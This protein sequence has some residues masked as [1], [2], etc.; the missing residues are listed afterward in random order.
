MIRKVLYICEDT[1]SAQFRYRCHNVME[2]TRRSKKWQVG[3]LTSAELEKAR[4]QLGGISLIVVERQTAKN[5]Q[6][7]DFVK[8][9][10]E[11]G[12]RVLYD[13]D[14]LVFDLRDLGVLMSATNSR[15]VLYWAGYVMGV[16]RLARVCDGFITTNEYLGKRLEKSF[17]KPFRVIHNSLNEEQIAAS[18][19]EI[20]KK[21]NEKEFVVGYFSGSPTHV[22]DFR[23]VEPE[24]IKFLEDFADAKLLIVGYMEL[25]E[26]MKIL[27]G[28]GRVVA[29]PFVEYKKLQKLVA[30][31]DVNIAPLEVNVFTN[32]KSE[33]KFFEAAVVETTTIASPAYAFKKAIQDGKNGFLVEPGGWY[34]KLKYLHENPKEN[35]AV[36]KQARKDVMRKYAGAELTKEIEAAYDFFA[37]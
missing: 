25:S 31:V 16:R 2:W 29:K 34:E 4:G 17:R 11:R 3:W 14:D 35:V 36:A 27:V 1:K 21:K 37:N 20:L 8:E 24:L 30:G 18:E 15:N 22:K 33:L 26:K 23:M 10:R 13:I 5:R 28:G 19:K 6:L 7:I 12:A 9:A 32:C